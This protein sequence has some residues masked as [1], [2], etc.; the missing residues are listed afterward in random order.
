[1]QLPALLTC[2]PWL[3]WLLWIGMLSPTVFLAAS[4]LGSSEWARDRHVAA[5]LLSERTHVQ[6]GDRW[7][8]ALELQ[9]DP[10]W[11]TYWTNGGDAGIP[12]TII[13]DLPEGIQAG[14]IHWAPPQIVKMGQL[15]VYG[16][17]DR[18]MLLIPFTAT[19]AL[20]EDRPSTIRAKV[21]W[22]MCART[23]LPGK[24]VSIELQLSPTSS[25][26]N[27][28]PLPWLDA[29]QRALHELP[30]EPKDMDSFTL[31]YD[32][33]TRHYSLRWRHSEKATHREIRSHVYFFDASGQVTSNQAQRM[34]GK[35]G[36]WTL[37]LP[38]A[39]YAPEKVGG[40]KGLLRIQED[41]AKNQ[42]RWLRL[43]LPLTQ[44]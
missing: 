20:R 9:H 41:A 40:L 11:H 37:E 14:T 21:N 15:D 3:K 39:D 16:Y 36:G 38:R 18:C 6:S 19:K 22:M 32:A 28:E 25:T 27:H 7:W 10:S 44:H 30:Q 1:M 43:E 2:L 17:E 8:V 23:C 13:W 42:F 5:R 34:T 35:Q 26:G 12:T 33:S 31:H 29:M 24:G 4:P